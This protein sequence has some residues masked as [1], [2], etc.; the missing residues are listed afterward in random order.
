MGQINENY[1]FRKVRSLT[2]HSGHVWTLGA[3]ASQMMWESGHM[4]IRGLA[5]S[6]QMGQVRSSS[7]FSITSLRNLTISALGASIFDVGF[8][9][10]DFWMILLIG[11]MRNLSWL[12]EP[13]FAIGHVNAMTFQNSKPDVKIL[14]LCTQEILSLGKPS[15][16][17]SAVFLNIVQK[18]FDPPPPFI[19]TFVLFCRGCFLKRVFEH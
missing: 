19:W 18:A 10:G 16:E 12:H 8:W 11:C 4:K 9:S 13:F 15:R 1:L 3:H 17:K 7:L 5:G 14:W 6:R 2:R